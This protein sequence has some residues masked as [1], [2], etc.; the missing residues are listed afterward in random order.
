LVISSTK[1]QMVCYTFPVI[2]FF[3]IFAARIIAKSAEI[4]QVAPKSFLGS[5]CKF[6]ALCGII[7]IFGYATIYSLA[8][9]NLYRR[10]NIREETSVWIEKNIPKGSKVTI[11]RSYFWTPGILRQYNPPYKLLMG[12][13]P[14]HSSVGEA[15]LGLEKILPETEYIILT[16]FEYRNFIHPK[17]EK[18]SPEQTKILKEIMSSDKFKKIAEFD[19]QASANIGGLWFTFKKN[20]P[21]SD[22]LIPNPKIIVFKKK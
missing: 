22:W 7:F 21:P 8:N 17:L 5:L 9:L 4:S 11:A 19:K 14:V 13:D 15:V 16:E 6:G 1:N 10:K 20:Y 18:Y 3:I 2:P 12:G